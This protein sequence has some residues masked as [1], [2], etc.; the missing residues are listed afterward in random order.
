MFAQYLWYRT[1]VRYRHHFIVKESQWVFDFDLCADQDNLDLPLIWTLQAAWPS[2]PRAHRA[3]LRLR[4]THM[5]AGNEVEKITRRTS[6]E[7]HVTDMLKQEY[8]PDGE[9]L[10]KSRMEFEVVELPHGRL[11]S[12]D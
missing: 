1:D 4:W 11:L 8:D 10:D 7:D 9:I 6:F 3:D 2:L 12:F 5:V